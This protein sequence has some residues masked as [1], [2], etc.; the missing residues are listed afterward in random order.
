MGELPPYYYAP[1]GEGRFKRHFEGIIPLIILIIIGIVLLGK[2]TS[3]FCGVPLLSDLF[4]GGKIINIAVIGDFN[5]EGT[6]EETAIKGQYLK[7][8]LDSPLGKSYNMYYNVYTPSTLTYAKEA[9]L[10]NYD[11]VILVGDRMFSRPV[12]DALQDYLG[13]GGKLIV[14]GDACTEDPDDP[15]YIGWGT[16]GLPV[17][18]NQDADLTGVRLHEPIQLQI[19]DINH[20]IVK[21]YGVQLDLTLIEDKPNCNDDLFVID[22]N[23]TTQDVVAMISGE[24]ADRRRDFLAVVEGGTLFGGKSMYFNFDPGCLPN[25]AISTIRYMTG[26]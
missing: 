20:P 8:L 15:L 12:K 21:G 22:V 6:E 4:C 9:L 3:V 17:R 11:L 2:T 23:P 26:K 16:I 19:F 10:K 25:L 13:A 14:I 24:H 5:A 18:L 7:E 1:A